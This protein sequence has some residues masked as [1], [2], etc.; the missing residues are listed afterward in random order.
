[1]P[2]AMIAFKNFWKTDRPAVLAN[3]LVR[4]TDVFKD[5]FDGQ[6]VS[7]SAARGGGIDNEN[8]KVMIA[9]DTIAF[10]TASGGVG[11][12]VAKNNG[13]LD[14]TSS[15]GMGDA[16]GAFSEASMPSTSSTTLRSSIISDNFDDTDHFTDNIALRPDNLGGTFFSQD[17]NLIG[18]SADFTLSGKTTYN[19]FGRNPMLGLLADNGGP[20][21]T[22]AICC[23]S[24]ALDAG[25][26]QILDLVS[27]DQ[28]GFSRKIGYYVAT[29]PG[30]VDIGAFEYGGTERDI[31]SQIQITRGGFYFNSNTNRYEQRLT[32]KNISTTFLEGPLRLVLEGFPDFVAL[33]NAA[34]TDSEFYDF[35]FV[36]VDIGNDNIFQVGEI[37][38]VPLEFSNPS[39]KPITYRARVLQVVPRP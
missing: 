34:G 4:L 24:P 21:F 19:L 12:N 25:D 16:G 38:S 7:G 13:Q 18:Q 22:H 3:A 39:D 28:R 2:H 20:T 23:G 11:F 17:F 36:S 32:L 14:M 5:D 37:P 27:T 1:M 33:A 8:G 30:A 15:I 26:N 35:P 6:G 29:P 9:A 31:T 10:N